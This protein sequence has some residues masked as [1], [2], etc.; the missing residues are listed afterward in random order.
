M[1][2]VYPNIS[3]GFKYLLSLLVDVYLV[4]TI[5]IL[6]NKILLNFIF[7]ART[8]VF[9][10]CFV[11]YFLVSYYFKKTSIGKYL[12]GI[13]IDF[14]GR[15]L[16]FNLKCK[17]ITVF[18]ISFLIFI[19]LSY[20]SLLLFN[21]YDNQP[22]KKILGFDFPFKN[23][24]YPN[25]S[26]F[27][28]YTEFLNK[29]EM[30]AKDY[31]L[32]L[33]DTYDIVVLC[34]NLHGEDS[35]WDLI[36]EVVSDKKFI[37]E[38]GNMFTE[39]GNSLFQHRVDTLMNSQFSTEKDLDKEVATLTSYI[40]GGSFY[41]FMKKLYLLNQALPDSLK[42]KEHFTDIFSQEYLTSA[43]YDSLDN[44]LDTIIYVRDSIMAYE[45]I[46]WYKKTNGKCLVVTN[47]RH[48]FAIN[49]ELKKDLYRK[50]K[51]N[52]AQYIYNELP[53]QTFNVLLNRRDYKFFC[54][55]KLFYF[56]QIRNGIW[57]T[58][59]RVNDNKSIG[60]DL[61]DSPFGNDKFEVFPEWNDDK[62]DLIFSEVFKGFVFYKPEE[63]YTSSKSLYQNYAATQ[64]YYQGMENNLID[65]TKAHQIIRRFYKDKT[66]RV[67]DKNASLLH[68]YDYLDIILWL[69][70]SIITFLAVTIR[71]I[72]YKFKNRTNN[73]K[74][75][76]T[77]VL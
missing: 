63:E 41:F 66:I 46:N 17:Y 33:F 58:A 1:K 32:S 24:Q 54:S 67:K 2:R 74:R 49:N 12:F 9:L 26:K 19:A 31:I 42:V 62:Y 77:S 44:N 22:E 10:I 5:S 76:K 72:A 69:I 4:F 61:K 21:N 51:T 11:L 36:Y 52:Q 35:Q 50:F 3:N 65:T 40:G 73:K 27:K 48:A 60:F 28:P 15:K 55:R 70:L 16:L 30:S 75:I 29:Q 57:N 71:Y 13:R 47:F 20:S 6:I 34:E 43:Y 53:T 45:T 68:Y 56:K 37:S 8:Y 38:V 25:N 7:V 23:I 64:E 59:F 14:K 39:Y 18:Y